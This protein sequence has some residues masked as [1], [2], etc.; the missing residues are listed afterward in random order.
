VA[1][2]H[3]P[4]DVRLVAYLTVAGAP[5]PSPADL[6]G[7]LRLRLPEYMVPAFF[8]VLAEFPLT[9]SGKADRKSLPE[10]AS[11]RPELRAQFVAPRDELEDTLAGLWRKVLGVDRVGMH[12]NFFE[13]GGHS[14]LMAELRTVLAAETGHE[15]SMV[16]LFQ[17]PTVASLAEHLSRPAD[18]TAGADLEARQRAENRR[19]AVRR[20]QP[21]AD[22]RTRS[23]SAG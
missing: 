20:R 7:H 16:E 2:E 14:L 12:D 1:R 10:P 17:H 6:A 5:A 19:R 11:I 21:I 3:R 9:P 22:R 13:L 8:E 18:A 4:G 15:V 23:Q